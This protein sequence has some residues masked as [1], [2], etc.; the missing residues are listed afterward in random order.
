MTRKKARNTC[1]ELP[2]LP[3]RILY[4]IIYLDH[5]TYP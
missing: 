3:T 2:Q 4:T 1:V 5:A